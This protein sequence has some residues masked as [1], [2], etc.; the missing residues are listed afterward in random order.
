MKSQY[1]E[2]LREKEMLINQI[3]N[4][5]RNI[6]RIG[7]HLIKKINLFAILLVLFLRINKLESSRTTN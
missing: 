5:E 7:K 1:E 2:I 4:Q 6:Q 3:E